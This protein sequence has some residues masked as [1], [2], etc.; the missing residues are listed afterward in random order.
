MHK[1]SLK[2]FLVILFFLCL[3][4]MPYGF[5]Q[6]TK[7]AAFVSFAGLSYLAYIDE[8]KRTAVIYTVLAFLFQPFFKT[9]FG[10]STWNVIDVLVS[11]FLICSI[12]FTASISIIK[13]EMTEEEKIDYENKKKEKLK[14]KS[15]DSEKIKSNKNDSLPPN[16][17]PI[18]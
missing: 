14:N 16:S 6:F 12:I 17:P 10:R 4:K 5:Y 2:I 13:R 15:A 18:G 3:A 11:I 9:S 1:K 7:F 8:R